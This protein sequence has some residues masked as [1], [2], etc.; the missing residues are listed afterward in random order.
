METQK[1]N[2]EGLLKK[3]HIKKIVYV[4]NEF[5]K[6][7]YEINCDEYIRSNINN[8]NIK[9]PFEG[10]VDAGLE[11]A[12]S[13]FHEWLKDVPQKEFEEWIKKQGISKSK[14]SI[15][16]KLEE[17]LPENI[18]TCL[19]PAEFINQ[20]NM[21]QLP[22][23]ETNQLLILMDMYLNDGDPKGG[24]R[25]LSQ[26][27]DQDYVA[28]GLFSNRFNIEEEINQ[29][30]NCDKANNIYPLAKKRVYTK[31]G[32]DLLCG[33]ENVIWLRQISD[34][35]NNV[36]G[37]Y[38]DA[39]SEA[40]EDIKS[41][42]P[43][44]FDLSII[45]TSKDEGCWEFDTMKRIIRLFVNYHIEE[46]L[47]N[48]AHFSTIQKQTKLLKE[49]GDISNCS[50]PPDTEIIKKLHKSEVYENI[51]YVNS[52]Y[53][54]I[55]NGDIFEIENRNKKELYM[56]SCQPCNLELRGD[57]LRK[58]S[59]FVYILPIE[60]I[61]KETENGQ[62]N[63]QKFISPLQNIN[64]TERKCVNLACGKRINPQILD[65]VC[66]NKRGEARININ[67]RSSDLEG[68]TLMQDNML[69]HYDSIKKNI[70]KYVNMI[71]EVNSIL[72]YFK[73]ES[74]PIILKLLKKPFEMSEERLLDPIC[75]GNDIN[76]KIKR[77]ARYRE[78]YAQII[79]QDF[80]DY[81]S[82]QALPNDFSKID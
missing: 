8:K 6:D 48:K 13:K 12:L 40:Q 51:N 79:L 47:I 58:S 41:L 30:K 73:K 29:W 50:A 68:A 1:I 21:S 44:S 4:D 77:V 59:E 71:Q 14:N 3:R 37:M 54:Q 11:F 78:P 55:C 39:L 28:C 80:K 10:G 56:L 24:M 69:R 42:D 27:K 61:V 81:Q 72:L 66:Y 34:I 45:H 17:I 38:K 18:L 43:A 22:L 67:K 19:T 64:E 76:F 57:T 15:E 2:I 26:F 75:S 35:K 53:S 23:S 74:R 70:S 65:L 82:R 9:W 63:R 5:E 16:K 46:L 52:T 33:L 62:K 32:Q 20:Y 25:L 31:D 49:I 7:A 60:P 36:C